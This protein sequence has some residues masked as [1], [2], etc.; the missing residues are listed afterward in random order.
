[1]KKPLCLLLAGLPILAILSG[2][3]DAA[4]RME[5][6]KFA[7]GL[8]TATINGRIKGNDG[9]SY[10]IGAKQGQT[11][12]VAFAPENPRC[13]FNVVE[14][15]AQAKTLHD[16]TAAG[17]S[18]SGTLPSSGEYLTQVYLVAEAAQH[19]EI[20]DYSIKIEVTG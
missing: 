19:N 7:A 6:L 10:I 13:Y 16:G 17:N 3:G 11:L 12:T 4:Q 1:M 20:C 2:A 15:D 18:Y 8:T 5:R 9:V 14:G